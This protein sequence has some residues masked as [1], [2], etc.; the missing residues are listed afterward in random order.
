MLARMVD[1]PTERSSARVIGPGKQILQPRIAVALMCAISIAGLFTIHT[2]VVRLFAVWRD[3]DLKSVGAVIPLISFVLV[4]RVWRR[5]GWETSHGTWWGFALLA[6]TSA[7][8]FVR[9]HML[10]IVTVRS[11]LLQ[12]PPLPLLA[13]VYLTAIVL[14]V[15]GMRLVRAALFPILLMLLVIP[16]PQTFSNAVDLPLQHVSAVVARHFAA[17]LGTPLTQDRLRLMFAPDY[18]MFIAPGCNGI[19]GSIT[20]GLVALVVG[21]LYRFRK[22][23]WALTIVASV[24]LGYLFNFVRLCLLVLYY[25]FTLPYPAL[26][27]HAKMADYLIGGSLFVCAVWLFIYVANRLRR[28]P[29]DVDVAAPAQPS[30][31]RRGGRQFLLRSGAVLALAAIFAVDFARTEAVRASEESSAAP[32]VAF[33]AQVGHFTLQRTW[34]ETMLGGLVVY[35]WAE[36][37]APVDGSPTSGAH[38]SLGISP[39]LGMH[40]TTTCHMTRGD[41]PLLHRELDAATANGEA[42]FSATLFNTGSSLRLEAASVCQGEVCRQHTD[43]GQHITLLY[44]RPDLRVATGQLRPVPVLLKAETNVTS[45]PLDQAA[46]RLGADMRSF[47]SAANLPEMTQPYSRQ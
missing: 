33:P 35:A 1:Q 45:M 6:G 28:H 29:E 37:A 31:P 42:T 39:R 27:G 38:V 47:L 4:L 44:N 22:G 15:D 7:L 26:H 8:V 30:E 11:W 14:M 20:L 9:D 3:N 23:V 13:A 2:A 21:Y 32:T 25:K 36:Y 16:V 17:A 19:R 34:N 41:D 43:A 24:L 5:L 12:I 40:D 10:L 18:G 46:D